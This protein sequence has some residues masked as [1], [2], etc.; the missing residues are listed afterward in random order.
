MHKK[1][2]KDHL[3]SME[4]QKTL[5]MIWVGKQFLHK[6]PPGACG[7]VSKAKGLPLLNQT[8]QAF[9]PRTPRENIAFCL[10]EED[11]W[12]LYYHY[13]LIIWK[14]LYLS[15]AVFIRW[16][17]QVERYQWHLRWSRHIWRHSFSSHLLLLPC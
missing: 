17:A 9:I 14:K 5:T 12:D 11:V 15:K 4:W 16:F 13:Y 7:L 6:F 1:K 10:V 2:F 8:L 3:K